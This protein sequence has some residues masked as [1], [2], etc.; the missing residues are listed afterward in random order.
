MI[1]LERPIELYTSEE[2]EFLVLRLEGAQL[3]RRTDDK[4]PSRVREVATTE[5]R[6]PVCTRLVEGGRWLLGV[7]DTGS[8]TYLDLDA[9]P[10]TESVLIP[11]QH[12]SLGTMMWTHMAVDVDRDSAFL[13]FNLALSFCTSY[14]V[15]HPTQHCVQIWKV[16]LICDA[17]QRGIGLAAE[18]CASFPQEPLIGRVEA[19]SLFGPYIALSVFCIESEHPGRAFVIDWLQADGDTT[20][21]R[22]RLVNPYEDWFSPVSD[23]SPNIWNSVDNVFEKVRA[24]SPSRKQTLNSAK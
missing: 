13:A 5:S 14:T 2:L 22:R 10:I 23:I 8:V 11:D 3:G 6:V 20:D 16:V 18:R 19:L 24:I 17:Q 4:C 1:H 12:P 9:S 7:S 15:T 21:Y